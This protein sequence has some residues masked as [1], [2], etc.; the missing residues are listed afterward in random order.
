MKAGA[1]AWLAAVLLAGGCASYSGS[2]LIPGKSTAREVE[3]LMGVPAQKLPGQAGET[4]WYYPR[5]PVGWHTYAV[6]VGPDGVLR[7]IE[8]RLTV[9]NVKKIVPGKTTKQDVLALLGPPFEVSR[10]PLK[11]LD[12]WQYQFLDV[13]YK[14]ILWVHFSDDGIVREVLQRP[15]PEQNPDWSGSDFP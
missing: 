11:P 14:W 9:E 7:G 13:A 15:H 12:V 4:V 8:Q 10:L 3:A 2:S 6:R 5:G 1:V